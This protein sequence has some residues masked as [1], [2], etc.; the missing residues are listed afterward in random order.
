VLLADVA[1]RE[2]GMRYRKALLSMQSAAFRLKRLLRQSGALD[3]SLLL[4]PE[5]N[6]AS[7]RSIGIGIDVDSQNRERTP[8]MDI[9]RQELLNS[10]GTRSDLL[11]WKLL[12]VGALGAAGLGLAGSTGI[13]GQPDLI[14]CAIPPVCLYVD[15]LSRHATMRTLVIGRYLASSKSS[16]LHEYERYAERARGLAKTGFRQVHEGKRSAFAFEDW[17]IFGSTLSLSMAVLVYG[18]F[19][20]GEFKAPFFLSGGLSVLLAAVALIVYRKRFDAVRELQP[21]PQTRSHGS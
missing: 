12:L 18:F 11:K 1:T 7:Y 9:L 8:S 5:E 17:A 19:V 2:K 16:D 4:A 15:L 13:T 3:A 21:E 6:L 14:L 20:P 10:Q